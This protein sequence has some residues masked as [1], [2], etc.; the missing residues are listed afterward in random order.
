[1]YVLLLEIDDIIKNPGNLYF[2]DTSPNNIIQ[3]SFTKIMFTH[4]QF[5]L[6][7]L[8]VMLPT[9]IHPF[10]I[11]RIQHMEKLILNYFAEYNGILDK[12]LVCTLHKVIANKIQYC[13]NNSKLMLKISGIWETKHSVGLTLKIM[14]YN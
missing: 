10:I 5:T 11:H 1:M 2:L 4:A 6:N 7:R 3:G 12:E 14:Q 13:N 9:H 8:F